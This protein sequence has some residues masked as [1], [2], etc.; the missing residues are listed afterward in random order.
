MAV[1][2][3]LD[4]FPEF[5]QDSPKLAFI[6]KHDLRV[7]KLDSGRWRCWLTD[8]TFGVGATEAEAI[9]DF[10]IKTGIK[11]YSLEG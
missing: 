6:K 4:A 9:I 7:V 5:F 11:H 1:A 2:D 10:C 3:Q 8:Q